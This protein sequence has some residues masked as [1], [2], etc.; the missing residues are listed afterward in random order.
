RLI[1]SMAPR[2]NVAAAFPHL[3]PFVGIRAE[4]HE[5]RFCLTTSPDAFASFALHGA[6]RSR[7]LTAEAFFALMRL[8]R[9]I[10]HP[11]PRRRAGRVNG[12]RYSYVF[13]FRRLPAEWPRLWDALLRGRSREALEQLSLRLLDHRGALARAALVQEDLRAL[14][15]FF[16]REAS[17]LAAAIR[18]T[19]YAQYPVAQ[20]DRDALFVRYRAAPADEDRTPSG[21]A[22]R[23]RDR[24]LDVP[25]SEP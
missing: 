1:Q 12:A 3:Y 15:R 18:A 14:G 20:R 24:V 17:R 21:T 19:G 11:S 22:E 10:G 2:E 5:T 25:G 8:L 16:E 9:F 7:E 6:F 13:G 4:P 23:L